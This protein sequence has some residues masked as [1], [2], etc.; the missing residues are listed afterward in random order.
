VP[1]ED[2]EAHD[3]AELT[4]VDR[5]MIAAVVDGMGRREYKR[6]RAYRNGWSNLATATV[7]VP[8]VS[9]V[10]GGT[11]SLQSAVLRIVLIL[12]L[13]R[14]IGGVVESL[15]NSYRSQAATEAVT[16]ALVKA[17]AAVSANSTIRDGKREFR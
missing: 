16:G 12:I 4:D 14:V 10:I 6:H 3:D 1:E 2:A 7:S 11:I 17:K 5:A 13:T 8:V 15:L 9:G